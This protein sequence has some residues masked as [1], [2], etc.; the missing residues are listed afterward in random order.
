MQHWAEYARKTAVSACYLNV[1]EEDGLIVASYVF[2]ILILRNLKSRPVNASLS[3]SCYS[4]KLA[5]QRAEFP[6]RLIDHPFR[7]AVH[8]STGS[9]LLCPLSE[10]HPVSLHTRSSLNRG[11]QPLRYCSQSNGRCSEPANRWIKRTSVAA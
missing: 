7:T 4:R 2:G 5:K 3:P 1:T 9:E 6:S 11:G 10:L 8:R